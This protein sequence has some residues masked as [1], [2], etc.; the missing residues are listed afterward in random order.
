[1]SIPVSQITVS[2]KE[3]SS[4]SWVLLLHHLLRLSPLCPTSHIQPHWPFS[5]SWP[6][7]ASRLRDLAFSVLS[8]WGHSFPTLFANS[9]PKCQL[10]RYPHPIHYCSCLPIYCLSIILFYFSWFEMVLFIHLI[11]ISSH[12]SLTEPRGLIC[13][14]YIT[15]V[16]LATTQCP[17]RGHLIHS[18]GD[19]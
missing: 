10:C 16:S 15:S 7:A 4:G 8:S 3:L 17:E 19:R 5:S 11:P 2:M 1:M 18:F 13:F 14:I 12:Q 9:L 6:W